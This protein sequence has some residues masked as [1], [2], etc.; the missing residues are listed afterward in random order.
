MNYKGG[1]LTSVANF[2]KLLGLLSRVELTPGFSDFIGN[3]KQAKSFKV[4][5]YTL[6]PAKAVLVQL[7]LKE[8]AFSSTS[9]MEYARDVYL[10]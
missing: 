1:S 2:K 8:Q 3:L 7:Y 6:T 9:E 10:Q 4:Q 5:S